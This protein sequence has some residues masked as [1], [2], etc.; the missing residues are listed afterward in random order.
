[1]R[2]WLW[3]ETINDTRRAKYLLS[4]SAAVKLTDF[5]AWPTGTCG[6]GAPCQYESVCYTETALNTKLLADKNKCEAVYK[7][8]T[9]PIWNVQ[10][11]AKDNLH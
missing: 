6:A 2:G 7:N 1:M 3:F 9:Q 11:T 10:V 8:G 4:Y 5:G